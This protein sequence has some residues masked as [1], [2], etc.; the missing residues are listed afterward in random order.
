MLEIRLQPFSVRLRGSKTTLDILV[1][2]ELPEGSV[3][4]DHFT[5]SQTTLFNDRFGIQAGSP[6]LGANDENTIVG[7]LVAGGTQTIAVKAGSDCDTISEAQCG[8]TVPWLGKARMVFVKILQFL[9]N[10][11]VETIRRRHQHRNG[12][13]DAAPAHGQNLKGIVQAG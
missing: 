10:G 3:D 12:V 7:D 6:H 9:R 1:A 5:R 13:K 2:K 4:G 8:R 11:W